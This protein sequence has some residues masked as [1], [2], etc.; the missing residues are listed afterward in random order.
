MPTAYAATGIA[1][2][3]VFDNAP[4]FAAL[5]TELGKLKLA[6]ADTAISMGLVAASAAT[7]AV[8]SKLIATQISLSNR[9]AAIGVKSLTAG[10]SVAV[11]NAVLNR[12][13]EL[14]GP[15][16]VFPVPPIPP[17]I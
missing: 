5:A 16:N 1:S 15:T 8:E 11:N 9:G 7:A 6:L 10:Q 14:A 4:E 17:G 13:N 2:G 12:R 3:T